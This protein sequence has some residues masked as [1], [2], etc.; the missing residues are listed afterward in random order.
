MTNLEIKQK[1]Q[2]KAHTW[3]MITFAVSL[4]LMSFFGVF[5][6]LLG[7]VAVGFIIDKIFYN[8]F[9]N[10]EVNKNI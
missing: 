8:I 7:A 6:G 5:V 1:A 4:S 3:G 10:A 9:Y 2:K